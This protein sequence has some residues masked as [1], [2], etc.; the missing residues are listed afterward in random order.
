MD[1]FEFDLNSI[2]DAF[3][4]KSDNIM[5]VS[6]LGPG[7]RPMPSEQI[8]VLITLSKNAMIGLGTEPIRRA[9]QDKY[10]NQHWHLDPTVRGDVDNST[11]Q[12]GVF[13]HPNST[14]VIFDQCEYGTLEDLLK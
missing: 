2:N 11:M 14:E 4:E 12:M 7:G 9:V 1:K 10:M 3:E 13:L 5:E 8:R 6:V